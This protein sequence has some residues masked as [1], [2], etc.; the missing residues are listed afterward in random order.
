MARPIVPFRRQCFIG[1]I[2]CFRQGQRCIQEDPALSA[3]G[4]ARQL[5][6]ADSLYERHQWRHADNNVDFQE[7][8]IAPHHAPS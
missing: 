4:G 3:I 2:H 5:C 8:I 1:G 6:D 7:F